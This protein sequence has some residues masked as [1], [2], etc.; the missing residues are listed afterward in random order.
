[1]PNDDRI[2]VMIE[3]QVSWCNFEE[4]QIKNLILLQALKLDGTWRQNWEEQIK[5]ANRPGEG[6]AVVSKRNKSSADFSHNISQSRSEE[7]LWNCFFSLKVKESTNMENDYVKREEEL[8]EWLLRI[9][10]HNWIVVFEI[11]NSERERTGRGKELIKPLKRSWLADNVQ[12][13][14]SKTG[15]LARSS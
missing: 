10:R 14:G 15:W 3:E 8:N 9:L 2:R 6:R 5:I 1:M 13:A 4:Q 11:R 12:D 7:R